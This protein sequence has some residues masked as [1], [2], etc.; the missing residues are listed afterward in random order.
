[1]NTRTTALLI[2]LP[3]L[4]IAAPALRAQDSSSMATSIELMRTNV[5]A[6]KAQIIGKALHLTDA[7]AN[8]FW[9]LYRE[10]EL[11]TAKLWDQRI[12]L[13]KDYAAVYDSLTDERARDIVMRA[14]D[15]DEQRIKL[16]R[17]EFNK[18]AKQLPAKTVAHFFQVNNYLDRIME[19][20]V[21]GSLPEMR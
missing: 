21:V 19:L 5:R 9:P 12:Q 18:L 1:M 16:N 10:F 7:Q 3:L 4:G 11:E 20:K 13:I 15:I 17:E 6:Q 2:L 14:W 8:V